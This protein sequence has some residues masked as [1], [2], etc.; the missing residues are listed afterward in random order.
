MSGTTASPR[1]T[2]DTAGNPQSVVRTMKALA[3]SSIG[4][5]QQS[6]CASGDDYRT[7]EPGLGVCFRDAGSSALMTGEK[8]ERIQV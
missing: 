6:A 7:V 2:I 4:Q 8:I 5:F 1:R 3:G